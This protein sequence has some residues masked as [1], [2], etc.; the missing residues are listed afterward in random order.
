MTGGGS[1]GRR[2]SGKPLL[3][4]RLKNNPG[5]PKPLPGPPGPPLYPL[6]APDV[7]LLAL[8]EYES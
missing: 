7:R 3:L 5:P 2:D 8:L 4:Q 6:L 1:N